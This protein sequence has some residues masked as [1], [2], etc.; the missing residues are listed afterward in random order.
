MEKMESA[1]CCPVCGGLVDVV[2]GSLDWKKQNVMA[3]GIT[4]ML[5]KALGIS[6]TTHF[7]GEG[8]CACGKKVVAT[9]HITAFDGEKT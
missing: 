6:G 9:L 3:A 2:M 5:D 8:K 1:V 4:S 7:E